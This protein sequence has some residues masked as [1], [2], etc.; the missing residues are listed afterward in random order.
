MIDPISDMISS[1]KNAAQAGHREVLIPFSNLKMNI[2]EIL[3]KKNVLEEVGLVE[4]DNAKKK[5]KLVPKYIETENGKTVPYLQG[6]RRVSRQG[7]RIYVGKN[8]IP[9]VK[10]KF[11]FAVISTSRGLMASDEARKSGVGGEVICEVW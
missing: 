3:K 4:E 9:F 2:A 8:K 7:Q 10:G 5:I 11:G 1:I 6:F